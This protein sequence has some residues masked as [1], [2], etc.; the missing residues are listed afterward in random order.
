MRGVCIFCKCVV[1]M[2][3]SSHCLLKHT[4]WISGRFETCHGSGSYGQE[5]AADGPKEQP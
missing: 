4:I 3:K 2:R 1:P 5:V